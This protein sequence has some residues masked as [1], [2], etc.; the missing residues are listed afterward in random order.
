MSGSIDHIA[1]LMRSKIINGEWQPGSRLPARTCLIKELSSCANTVQEA[2][3]CLVDEGF[4]E[5][6]A[7]KKGTYVVENPPHLSRYRLIFP[8]GPDAWGQFWRAIEAAAQQRTT[9]SCEF[10]CFYG[11]SGHRDIAEYQQVVNEVKTKGIAGLIFVSSATELTGTPLL[12]TPGLPRVAIAGSNELP[13]MPKVCIDRRSFVTMAMEHLAAQ[14]KRKVAILCGSGAGEMLDIFHD[15]VKQYGLVSHNYW[16]QFASLKNPLAARNL[17]EL[18]LHPTQPDRPD[19]II[20]A[21]DNLIQGATAGIAA[22]GINVPQELA[23]V[24]MTNFPNVLEAAVPVVR[25]GFDVPGILDTLTTRLRELKQGTTPREITTV[26]AI[27]D[28]DIKL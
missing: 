12:T 16:E 3:S 7:R 6:G 11:L 5:T 21:D 18:M 19:A 1:S 28:A 22:T 17:M 25:I 15:V 9:Q 14:N 26:S 23:V 10:S 27:T 24:A 8:F 13:G 2:V 20:I 4:I